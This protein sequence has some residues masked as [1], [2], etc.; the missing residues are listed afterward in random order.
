M[1][2]TVDT[3]DAILM[4]PTRLSQ[5]YCRVLCLVRLNTSRSLIHRAF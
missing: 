4:L 1:P 3:T 2:Y 5:R